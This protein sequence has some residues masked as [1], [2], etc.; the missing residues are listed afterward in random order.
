MNDNDRSNLRFLLESSAEQLQDWYESVSSDDI[1]YAFALM[2]T[3]RAEIIDAVTSHDTELK[4]A[5]LILQRFRL[6]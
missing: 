3:A 4:D 5:S 1:E 2:E 6:K